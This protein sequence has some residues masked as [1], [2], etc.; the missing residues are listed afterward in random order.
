MLARLIGWSIRNPV[1]VVLATLLSVGLGA[2]ALSETPIDALPD[3]SDA[4]VIVYTEHKGQSPRIVEDQ[5]TYPL[6]TSLVS[7]PGARWCAA[8]PSSATPWCTSS[9]PDG[10]DIYWARSRV[11]EYLNYGPEAPAGGGRPDPGAR[12]QRGRL[13]FRIR[14]GIG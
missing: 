1:L 3:L 5:V 6:T 14:I 10:T 7:V 12:C 4:Q 2:W 9:S 13:G 8:I 11:L